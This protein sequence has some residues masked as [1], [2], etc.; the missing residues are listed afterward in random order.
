MSFSKL[1]PS[2]N[3][4]PKYTIKAMDE[5]SI[6]IEDYPASEYIEEAMERIAELTDKLAKKK[7]KNAEQYK[8]MGYY[9][10]AKSTFLDVLEYYMNTKWAQ[11]AMY[12]IGECEMKLND[13]ESAKITFEEFLRRY[14][15]NRLSEKAKLKLNEINNDKKFSKKK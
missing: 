4:D 7:F 5:Y 3:L 1:S 12:H 13:Y 14:P 9:T 15:D 6:L 10:A 11:E 8:K 2:Y